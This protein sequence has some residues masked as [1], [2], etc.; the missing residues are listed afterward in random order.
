[1]VAGL[2][3]ETGEEQRA[4]GIFLADAGPVRARGGESFRFFPGVV[5]EA[6]E[7]QGPQAPEGKGLTGG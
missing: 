5:H 4:L 3:E 1:M 6:F 2:A 7:Q